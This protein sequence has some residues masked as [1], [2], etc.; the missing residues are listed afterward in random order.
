[1]SVELDLDALN[2]KA[3]LLLALEVNLPGKYRRWSEKRL[4]KALLPYFVAPPLPEEDGK[5]EASVRVL[6]IRAARQAGQE[7]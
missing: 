1:M 4:R 3:L 5:P 7:L 2:K 6:R